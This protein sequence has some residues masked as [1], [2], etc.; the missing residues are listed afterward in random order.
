MAAVGRQPLRVA[1]VGAGVWL[2]GV[3]FRLRLDGVASQQF[4][5]TV[6]GRDGALRRRITEA[7][8][9]HRQWLMERSG[10]IGLLDPDVVL[11]V[12]SDA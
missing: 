9:G 5:S 1:L 4:A 11:V 6:S 10:D 3:G 7:I 8:A 12:L 2:D